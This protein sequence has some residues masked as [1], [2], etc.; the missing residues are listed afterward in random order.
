MGEDNAFGGIIG[1][2]RYKQTMQAFGM[3]RIRVRV[4][5]RGALYEDSGTE[6]YGW[7]IFP[8]IERAYKLPVKANGAGGKVAVIND[9]DLKYDSWLMYKIIQTRV[10]A[11][12]ILDYGALRAQFMIGLF[13]GIFLGAAGGLVGMRYIALLVIVGVVYKMIN[14]SVGYAKS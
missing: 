5:I 1:V 12:P 4:L 2:I 3:G 10:C 9:A 6:K 7:G 11:D 8:T 13:I 14:R